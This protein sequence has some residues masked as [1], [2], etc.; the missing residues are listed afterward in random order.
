MEEHRPGE[1][2]FFR[3]RFAGAGGVEPFENSQALS[4][5]KEA[6]EREREQP[7]PRNTHLAG[8]C[9]GSLKE[10]LSEGDGGLDCRC[11]FYHWLYHGSERAA[12]EFDVRIHSGR[13]Q[14]ARGTENASF[15]NAGNGPAAGVTGGIRRP[16]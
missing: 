4:L 15:V 13:S 14:P 8:N 9:L 11:H 10:I 12:I 5:V 7:A 3:S 6:F 16:E 1:V 2:A